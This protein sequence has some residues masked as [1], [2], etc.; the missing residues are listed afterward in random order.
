MS[1]VNKSFAEETTF[2]HP[3][4]VVSSNQVV[5]LKYVL[6][7]TY[8]GNFKTTFPIMCNRKVRFVS[9]HMFASWFWFEN[10]KLKHFSKDLKNFDEN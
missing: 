7:I 10:L 5:S 8:S 3:N 6:S 4:Q 1:E 9:V 2:I